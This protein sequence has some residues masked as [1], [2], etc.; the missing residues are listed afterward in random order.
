MPLLYVYFTLCYSVCA[1][2]MASQ[3][4]KKQEGKKWVLEKI[5]PR[6][7]FG[8]RTCVSVVPANMTTLKKHTQTVRS[9]KNRAQKKVA[10]VYEK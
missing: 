4:F 7:V 5:A 2:L 8:V 10:G 9:E 3:L 1:L 6:V